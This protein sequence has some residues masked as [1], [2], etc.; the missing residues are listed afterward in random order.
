MGANYWI[1]YYVPFLQILK[2][3]DIDINKDALFSVYYLTFKYK[4]TKLIYKRD[5]NDIFLGYIAAL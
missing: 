4:E 3:L 5:K 1:S 2:S